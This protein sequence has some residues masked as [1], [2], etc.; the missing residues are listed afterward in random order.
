MRP[1]SATPSVTRR[2]VKNPDD[3]FAQMEGVITKDTWPA[4][5]PELPSD[6]IYNMVYGNEPAEGNQRIFVLRG[7]ANGFEVQLTFKNS[8]GKWR[9]VKMIT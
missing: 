4:F 8:G 9:L 3:D 5:A 7:I 1:C 6:M 2:L